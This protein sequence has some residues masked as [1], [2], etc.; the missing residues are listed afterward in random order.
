MRLKG[1]VRLRSNW[2]SVVSTSFLAS[3]LAFLAAAWTI[4][5]Y[6]IRGTWIAIAAVLLVAHSGLRLLWLLGG[7]AD[8]VEDEDRENSSPPVDAIDSARE[9]RARPLDKVVHRRA[10]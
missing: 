10:L 1:G 5:D 6:P 7:L 2:I 9:R 4:F 8:V 3:L